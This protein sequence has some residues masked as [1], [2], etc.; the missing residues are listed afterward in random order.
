M[1]GSDRV[2][3]LSIVRIFLFRLQ[4][5]A[6]WYVVRSTQPT[7]SKRVPNFVAQFSLCRALMRPGIDL[8]S[9][10]SE[11]ERLRFLD[12]DNLDSAQLQTRFACRMYNPAK[13]PENYP[14]T[15]Q[16]FFCDLTHAIKVPLVSTEDRGEVRIEKTISI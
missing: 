9:V 7:T 16:F 11:R 15:S 5:G 1:S 2:P 6:R 3:V 12:V 4:F 13:T 14:Q 8:V 10:C